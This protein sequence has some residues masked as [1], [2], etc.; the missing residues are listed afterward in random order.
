MTDFIAIIV[1]VAAVVSSL[2]PDFSALATPAAIAAGSTLL[3]ERFSGR[4]IGF[5]FE[6][7]IINSFSTLC[8]SDR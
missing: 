7:C 1:G 4:K 5:S 8:L 6:R 3:L 2:S